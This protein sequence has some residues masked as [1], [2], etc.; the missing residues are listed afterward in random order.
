MRALVLLFALALPAVAHAADDD[1]VR[2]RRFFRAG[3]IAYERG[4]YAEAIRAFEEAD[5]LVDSPALTF[6]LA[7]A[8]RRQFFVDRDPERAERAYE[9]F[10]AYLSADPNGR[11]RPD[12][13][14]QIQAL[15]VALFRLERTDVLKQA[16]EPPPPPPPATELFLY[17]EG[18]DAEVAVDGAA[19]TRAPTVAPVSAGRH[20]VTAEA[21]GYRPA[22]LEIDAA[23]NRLTP[24]QIVLEPRPA[25][26]ALEAEPGAE[27]F[28][29][30]VR[31]G[32]APLAFELGVP[33]GPHRIDARLRGHALVTEEIE[34][35]RDEAMKRVLEFEPTPRREAANVVLVTSGGL[36]AAGVIAVVA[37]LLAESEASGVDAMRGS[38][39]IDPEVLED[40][41]GD[42]RERNTLRT[43]SV[44]LFSSAV[45]LGVVGG[46]MWLFDEPEIPPPPTYLPP[47]EPAT[48]F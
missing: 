13:V 30:G 48:P 4:R 37:A 14:E 42:V 18:A 20:V 5:A 27:I 40:Y 26:L 28:V 38:A 23:P 7:Q 32:E 12:A 16:L 29:D 25:R 35:E 11:R 22:R 41:N 36:A 15:E 1:M 31:I 2:A 45:V 43:T 6:S 21:P 17:T 44:V 9:L 3:S 33:P 10:R 46:V 39:N 8:Y 47:P 34:A 19:A 24:V